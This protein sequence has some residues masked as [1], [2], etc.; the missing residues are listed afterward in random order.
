MDNAPSTSR[1]LFATAAV[2]TCAVVL[3]AA[4]ARNAEFVQAQQANSSALREYTWKSRTELSL[5]GEVKNIKL[6]QVRYD[7]DGRLQKTPIGGAAEESSS[8]RRGGPIGKR[9]A[10]RKKEEFKELMQELAALAGG[11]S[12][13]PLD[14]D[15]GVRQPGDHQ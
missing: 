1:R 10:A 8:P 3:A 4:S 15:A 12:H 6:E 13:L 9:V 7:L 5:H 11:Y 14:T 2:F